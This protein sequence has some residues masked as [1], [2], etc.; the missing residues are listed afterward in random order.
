MNTND[1]LLGESDQVSHVYPV[2]RDNQGNNRNFE[3]HLLLGSGCWC[4]PVIEIRDGSVYVVH[5]R[6]VAN[7]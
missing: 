4:H 5:S 6:R 7:D 2:T 1:V 3:G